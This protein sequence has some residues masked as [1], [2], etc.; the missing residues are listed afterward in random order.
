[1]FAASTPEPTLSDAQG[2]L[3]SIA[4]VA[5]QVKLAGS[6]ETGWGLVAAPLTVGWVIETNRPANL[7]GSERARGFC[8]LGNKKNF[9]EARA[10]SLKGKVALVTGSSRGIGRAIVERLSR[11]GAAAIDASADPTA[12]A[13]AQAAG[14]WPQAARPTLRCA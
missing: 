3:G 9:E 13:C 12:A 1:V 7:A 6:T 11:D 8:P 14:A 5:G 2:R 10:M 4:G